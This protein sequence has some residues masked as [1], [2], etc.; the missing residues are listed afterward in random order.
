[1]RRAYEVMVGLEVHVALSTRSKLFSGSSTLPTHVPNSQVSPFDAAHPGTLPRTNQ[2]AVELG[3]RAALALHSN[4]P[5]LSTFQRKHYFYAD[6]PHGYQVTQ[7]DAPLA[8]GGFL[9]YR[10]PRGLHARSPAAVVAVMPP[11]CGWCASPACSWRWTLASPT[12][13]WCRAPA[14]WTSTARGRRCWRW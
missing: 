2:G 7:L 3:V 10:P 13:R 5:R 1:M 14:W 11:T 12:T 6:L 9:V 4:I 8:L